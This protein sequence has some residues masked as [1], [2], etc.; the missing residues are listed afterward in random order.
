MKMKAVIFDLFE[1]LV[2]FSFDQYD[3]TLISMAEHVGKEPETFVSSWHAAW[4]RHEAGAFKNVAD[5]IVAVSGPVASE[6]RLLAAVAIHEAF[7]KQVLIPHPEIIAILKNLKDAG[8]KIGLITNCPVETP[9][10]WPESCL[11]ELVDVAVFSTVEGIRKPDPE[12]FISCLD[13]LGF[14]PTECM[15]VGDGANDELFASSALGM[16]TIKLSSGDKDGKR[17]TNEWEG[18]VISHLSELISC[19]EENGK[20][21]NECVHPIAEKADSG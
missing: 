2:D 7:Q 6:S 12:L 15:Y 5:Y 9:T 16:H 19:I 18:P 3:R 20:A 8:Y 11:S 21:P 1:T 17:R 4:A 10:L 13:R 14:R